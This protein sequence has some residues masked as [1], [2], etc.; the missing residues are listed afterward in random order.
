MAYR[1]YATAVSHIVDTTGQG[2]FTTI[3]AAITAATSGMTIFIRP[4]NYSESLILKAGV[5]LTA[6][7]SDSSLNGTGEVQI[8]GKATLSTAGTV[9][10]SGIQLNTSSD[11]FLVVS[12]SNASIVNMNDCF[13]NCVNNTGISFTASNAAAQINM[14]FCKGDLGTTGIGLFSGSSTGQLQMFASYF[15][16]SGSSLTATTM[17]AGSWL[18]YMSVFNFPMSTTSTAAMAMENCVISQSVNAIA[19]TVNGSGNGNAF[20]T[21]FVSGTSSAISVGTGASLAMY[22]CTSSS[23]NTNAWTGAGTLKTFGNVFNG[24][25]HQSNV[26]TQTGGAASGLTQ[27]TAPSAGFIGEILSASASAVATTTATSKTITSVSLTPGIWDVS[28]QAGAI[29][30]GGATL[31]QSMFLGVSPTTNTLVGTQG[32]DYLGTAI[33][34]TALTLSVI[35]VRVTLSATTTYYAVVQNGYTSTTCPTAAIIRAVRVG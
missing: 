35:P 16:N 20:A 9:T 11:F 14:F 32:I 29:A 27:G 6:F 17:S 24:S 23:S 21:Y 10:I 8:T 19:L 5:S 33:T 31:M 26:T 3:Q 28:A 4:G 22:G 30:T 7:G 34:T 12:G 2:D 1:N 18:A 13:L 15:S 25:S